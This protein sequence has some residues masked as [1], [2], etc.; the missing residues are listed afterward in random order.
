VKADVPRFLAD[1]GAHRV[2]VADANLLIY[3]LEGLAPYVDL[4]GELLTYLSGSDL[5][6][7]VSTLT[8]AEVLA[9]PYRAHSHAKVA[10]AT[11]FLNSLPHA[12]WVDVSMPIADRAAWLRSQGLRMPDALVMGTALVHGADVLLT[13][14]PVF[15]R[16]IRGA[17]RVLL[18]DDYCRRA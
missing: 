1:L 6:L 2:A 10:Q 18:L 15:R 13:N 7:V 4:T 9:G 12:E 8:A 5:R 14:D 16:R 3:H 17:P 11:T